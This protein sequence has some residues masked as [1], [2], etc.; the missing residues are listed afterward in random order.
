MRE[1][2]YRLTCEM[3]LVH[4][5]GDICRPRPE[6]R[7]PRSRH[8]SAQQETENVTLSSPCRPPTMSPIIILK[9]IFNEPPHTHDKPLQ[10]CCASPLPHIKA[11]LIHIKGQEHWRSWKQNR[12]FS[13]CRR[14]AAARLSWSC[15]EHPRSRSGWL[16]YLDNY[17]SHRHT[18]TDT[19]PLL[20]SSK[21]T[22]D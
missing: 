9:V 21:S 14:Q 4:V 22:I 10:M 7:P 16:S 20:K 18:H 3:M 19:K 17:L 13:A 12:P 5:S 11:P 6:Q 2:W 15:Y 8:S 1:D